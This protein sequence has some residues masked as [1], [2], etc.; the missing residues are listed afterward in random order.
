M[1]SSQ[2]KAVQVSSVPSQCLLCLHPRERFAL[3]VALD[4][5][6]VPDVWETRTFHALLTRTQITRSR[7]DGPAII[8]WSSVGRVTSDGEFAILMRG[9]DDEKESAV[10]KWS[11]NIII[12]GRL[13]HSTKPKKKIGQSSKKKK[14]CAAFISAFA[15]LD[16][17]SSSV[18]STWGLFRHLS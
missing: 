12:N 11:E 9:D 5:K 1:L 6:C 8:L 2:C 3:P 17:R 14:S 15:I 4:V 13:V 10:K 7:I 16:W 18:A